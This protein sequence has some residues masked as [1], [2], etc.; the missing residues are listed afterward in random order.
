MGENFLLSV[1]FRRHF[2]HLI[3]LEGN[4]P[5]PACC[6]PCVLNSVTVLTKRKKVIESVK[7]SNK[8]L[9]ISP[10]SNNNLD[11]CKMD[12]GAPGASDASQVCV[13]LGSV[14]KRRSWCCPLQLG[15]PRGHWSGGITESLW[16][17]EPRIGPQ[18]NATLEISRQEW[19][20]MCGCGVQR[21]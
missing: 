11:N 18:S 8:H 20:L 1:L 3:T 6:V 19:T 21:R 12:S 2:C 15:L 13:T 5:R 16:P 9:M 17:C 10:P 4:F 14:P 7:M